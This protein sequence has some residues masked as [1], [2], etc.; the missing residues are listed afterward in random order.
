M[1]LNLHH[2]P[3]VYVKKFTPYPCQITNFN[4]Q[5]PPKISKAF[6]ITCINTV[7][8]QLAKASKKKL[9][10]LFLLNLLLKH[11]AKKTYVH[12]T[13]FKILMLKGRFLPENLFNIHTPPAVL[14]QSQ[15]IYHYNNMSERA[16]E[17]KTTPFQNTL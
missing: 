12:G 10:W 15:K 1:L 9:K 14:L 2:R 17:K 4:P 7:Q 3:N 5:Y 8:K 6:S 13:Y 11:H 16:R